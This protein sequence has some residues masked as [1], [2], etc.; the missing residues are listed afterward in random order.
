VQ[1]GLGAFV[2][3]ATAALEIGAGLFDHLA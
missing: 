1:D 2:E 3:F